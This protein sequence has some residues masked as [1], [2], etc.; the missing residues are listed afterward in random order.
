M[1]PSTSDQAHALRTRVGGV[2]AAPP[3]AGPPVIAIASGKGGVGKSNVAVNLACQAG[4]LGKRVLL[5]DADFGLGNTDILLGITPTAT[6]ADAMV[7]QGTLEDVAI[8][9][10]HG[11]TLIP[12]GS[13]RFA[14]ANANAMMVEG[15]FYELER[16][17]RDF[18]LVIVDTGAGIGKRVRDTLLV[19]DRIVIVTTPDPTA[20][21]D[22]YATIKVVAQRD[23]TKRFSVVVNMAQSQGEAVF[24]Q[25]AQVAKKY[26]GL[27]LESLGSIPLDPRVPEAIRR[28]QAVTTCFPGAPASLA[29]RALTG[30]ILNQPVAMP[31]PASFKTF[32]QQ[33]FGG[34]DAPRRSVAISA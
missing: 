13:G 31:S 27:T 18:D 6:L 19:A 4:R 5:F 14:A 1:K 9:L 34:T 8:T 17:A 16:F 28:Q 26:L 12:S 33:F 15:I 24:A 23:M 20:L 30:L 22:S 7:G 21:T 2:M 11:V 25:L 29:L 3:P 32:L 10:P